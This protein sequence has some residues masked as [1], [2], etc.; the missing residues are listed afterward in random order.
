MKI[1]TLLSTSSAVLGLLGAT[2]LGFTWHEFLT[3]REYDVL[4]RDATRA[5]LVVKDVN[6]HVIQVQ[7]FLTDVGASH[8]DR[9]YGQ[10]DAHRR[11]AA[12]GLAELARLLPERAPQFAALTTRVEALHTTGVE[13]AKEYV[14]KGTEAG[15]VIMKR[16]GTGFDDVTSALSAELD[17]VLGDLQRRHEEVTAENEALH[18][19]VRMLVTGV[20]AAFVALI[21]TYQFTIYRHVVPPLRHLTDAIEDIA[22]G[23]GDLT[24]RLPKASDDEVGDI[25]VGLN[26]FMAKLHGVVSD[27]I[28]QAE[29]L[30][31][32]A[33]GLA[34]LG[35]TARSG[36]ERQKAE[37][38]QVSAAMTEMASTVHE[39]ASNAIGASDASERANTRAATGSEEVGRAISSINDLARDI[40]T[41]VTLLERLEASSMQIS[42]VLTVIADIAGQ[43]NLLALNAA[44]EAARAGEQGRGFAVVADEVRTLASRTEKST[45]EIGGIIAELQ[46]ESQNAVASMKRA[47]DKARESVRTTHD[48]GEAFGMIADDISR[49][50]GM[51]HQIA[52]AAE[53]QSAAGEDI[54]RNV[55]NIASLVDETASG[56]NELAAACAD[57]S[58]LAGE[59]NRAVGHFS[60]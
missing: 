43:T 16:A 32:T 40:D 18:A 36:A 34:A 60:V 17:V 9:G 2:V 3:S 20:I 57:L 42:K 30:N 35:A 22:Q 46:S 12:T 31:G 23:D 33:S 51:N 6:K 44:I 37:I 49:I 56:A 5:V 48:A 58:R 21:W 54:N 19:R 26:H 47:N 29:V 50:S 59:L 4:T 27:I 38:F 13:M 15:N 45:H 11:D 8:D 25:I 41:S 55:A 39:V 53:Q 28:A 7:Q 1:R 10:A 14:A 52:S 24:H